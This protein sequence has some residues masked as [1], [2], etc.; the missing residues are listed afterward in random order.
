MLET[1]YRET[2]VLFFHVSLVSR[3]T[4]LEEEPLGAAKFLV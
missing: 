4:S 2:G 3:L 1:C